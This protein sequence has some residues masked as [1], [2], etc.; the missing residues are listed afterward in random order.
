MKPC[1]MTIQD[2]FKTQKCCLRI[3]PFLLWAEAG[4]HMQTR[5]PM[6]PSCVVTSQAGSPE[7]TARCLKICL[8]CRL[9]TSVRWCQRSITASEPKSATCQVFRLWEKRHE[10][11][12]QATILSA[13]SHLVKPI[14]RNGCLTGIAVLSSHLLQ[15]VELAMSR[16]SAAAALRESFGDRRPPD[17]SRKITAC[18]SCRKLKVPMHI[19][20]IR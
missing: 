2:H 15:C 17:I 10:V 18:V 3:A 7:M 5:W 9:Y 20:V 1:C 13:S 19:L 14:H 12:V 16:S 4:E 6:R 11:R 8:I